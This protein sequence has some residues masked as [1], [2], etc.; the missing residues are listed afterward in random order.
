MSDQRRTALE[1]VASVWNGHDIRYGVVH[2]LESYPGALGRD[3]DV[4]VHPAD[5]EFA[6]NLAAR[7]LAAM[8]FE[9]GRPGDVW[10]KRLVAVPP[11]RSWSEAL[12][13]HTIQDLSWRNVTLARR[14]TASRRVGP[15]LVDDEAGF[16]KST[17]LPLLAGNGRRFI[18]EFR[19]ESVFSEADAIEKLETVLGKKLGTVLGV[20]ASRMDETGVERLIPRIRRTLSLRSLASEPIRSIT[21]TRRWMTKG[22]TWAVSPSAPV[23]ALF[24]PDGVGKTSVAKELVSG[25]RSVFTSIVVRHWR[26]G[27]LPP[28]AALRGRK[29]V[30]TLNGAVPPRRH[31]GRF[32][33]LRVAYYACD[34]ILGYWLRDRIDVSRQRLVVYDRHAL[35]MSIDHVRYGLNSAPA[36]RSIP[37]MLP[38]ADLAIYLS[39]PPE[40]IHRRKPELEISEITR[41]CRE[42]ERAAARGQV[43]VIVSV[44]GDPDEVA[45]KIRGLVMTTLI[46][47][48]GGDYRPGSIDIN[49][50]VSNP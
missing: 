5:Q 42:W 38:R 48:V 11:Q 25:D 21:A 24:G 17:L 33:T 23:V 45:E 3:L 1:N 44:D 35:D 27:I 39:A 32:G 10:G 46:S 12:E 37:S 8:N 9:V 19:G 2:G 49:R 22:L 28:L 15:F 13:I 40:E 4:L 31:A 50:R 16:L 14:P 26:P 29:T 18:Q 30:P 7:R 47:T 41:Q 20:A 6:V 43:D 34:F 36:V